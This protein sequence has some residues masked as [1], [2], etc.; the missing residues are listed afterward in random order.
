MTWHEHDLLHRYLAELPRAAPPLLLLVG[1]EER[2]STLLS[3]TATAAQI[4]YVALSRE[5]GSR[6]LEASPRERTRRA[7]RTFRELLRSYQHQML[8]L[9][10][11]ALLFLPELYLNPFQLL[12]DTSRTL[13]PL[14]AA[15]PGQ[16]D[17]TT[18][19]YAA[20]GHPEYQ[21]VVRPE[22]LV[23]SVV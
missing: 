9:D 13:C 16:W 6:L 19:T 14:V 8:V 3:D 17:G 1:A 23:V 12:S 4:P 10:R 21:R 11:T 7:A 2:V 18:L 15:W 22:A 20:P 5:L